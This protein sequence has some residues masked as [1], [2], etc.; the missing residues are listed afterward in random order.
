MFEKINKAVINGKCFTE[1][2]DILLYEN[3][4][5]RISII[6]GKNGSGKSTLG[7]A[8]EHIHFPNDNIKK[9]SLVDFENNELLLDESL[10]NNIFVFNEE[11]INKNISISGDGL[12]T[13]IMLGEQNDVEKEIVDCKTKLD[14][15]RINYEKLKGECDKLSDKNEISSPLN[16]KEKFLKVLKSEQG[17]A[18]RDSDIK[19]N[20][21]KSRVVFDVMVDKLNLLKVSDTEVDLRKSFKD[22]LELYKKSGNI[23][24]EYRDEIK[25]VV[26]P[27]CI[28]DSVVK[29]LSEEVKK[30]NFQI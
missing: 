23:E 29:L 9:V 8:I 22:T 3:S 20:A 11:F 4:K 2:T 1:D 26:S 17:W 24:T 16:I 5:N 30:S 14:K 13:I 12:S 10:K 7:E 18:K 15:V 25:P 19:G 6:Y 28:D 27:S 21:N